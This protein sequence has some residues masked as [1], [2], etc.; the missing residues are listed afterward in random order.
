MKKHSPLLYTLIYCLILLLI[1]GGMSYIISVQPV[2]GNDIREQEEQEPTQ[3]ASLVKPAQ[4]VKENDESHETD[5]S[6]DPWSKIEGSDS[7]SI[8]ELVGAHCLIIRKP[9]A[10]ESG[11]ALS[12][13]SQPIDRQLCVTISGCSDETY[14]AADIARISQGQYFQGDPV[15]TSEGEGDLLYVLDIQSLTGVND[16]TVIS[17]CFTL[18]TVYEYQLYED[19][20][21]YYIGL[22]KPDETG[23]TVIVLD[24]GHGGWDTGAYSGDYR[25]LE[26][27]ITLQILLDVKALLEADDAYLVYCTRTTDR[28]LTNEQRK[29]LALDAGADLF[30]SLHC[31]NDEDSMKQGVCIYYSPSAQNT[32]AADMLENITAYTGLKKLGVFSGDEDKPLFGDM[33][34]PVMI[35]ETGY[36]SNDDD[37]NILKS[38]DFQQ[39]IAD[40]VYQSICKGLADGSLCVE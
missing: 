40:A 36:L 24:A 32:F 38:P 11:L 27:D 33:E 7:S 8:Q 35:L 37:L 9:E 21:Y 26:K 28:R 23:K 16:E 5:S 31:S 2:S 13:V 12:V 17:L 25:Y 4:T 22:K 34:L 1:A 15:T 29:A 6:N 19:A 14:V 18:D 3:A 10:G 20:R 30:L 39:K